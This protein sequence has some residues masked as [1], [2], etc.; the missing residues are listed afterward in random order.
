[1]TP[2]NNAFAKAEMLIRKPASEVFNAFVDPQITTRFWFTKSTGLLKPGAHVQ[3][4]WEM[5]D[6]TET[7]L[8]KAVEPDLRLVIEWGSE[9]AKTVVEWTFTQIDANS[10]F[11]SVVNEGFRGDHQDIIAQI[12]DSTEGF[13]LVLAG[14]KALMEHGIQLNLIADRFPA[15]LHG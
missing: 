2:T 13:T 4:T 3:W 9:E 6:Y 1:M 15:G 5:Y 8:V 11:V 12:R 7:I 14:L 10:T